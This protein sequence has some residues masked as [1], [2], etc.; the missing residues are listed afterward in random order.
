[1]NN[2]RV[3]VTDFGI[4]RAVTS[5]TITQTGSV[6][7]SVHYFSPEH[8]KGINT[9]EKSDLYSL[10]IV[11]YQML[12]GK[13]PF[14]GESP[15]S[16]AL[17]HLQ[18]PFDEP[19]VV[20]P[21]I[22]QSVENVILKSMRKNPSERYDSA[23]D[24]L[25]D[26]DT[27]LRPERLDEPRA[28]FVANHDM[29]ETR[30][31]PAIRGNVAAAS[32]DTAVRKEQKAAV[33]DTTSVNWQEEENKPKGW[34]KPLLVVGI[35]LLLLAL[36][37]LGFR[38]VLG[39]LD[40]G[41]VE[42]PNV[43]G[44]TEEAAKTELEKV[45]LK[46]YEP[47]TREFQK[48]I[49]KGEVYEQSPTNVTVKKGRYIEISVSDGPEMKE[50]KSYVGKKLQEA[51]DE[52]IAL[53]IA[54]DR[55]KVT[56]EHSEEDA[57][58]ILEQTPNEGEMLNPEIAEVSFVVSKGKET[59]PMEDLTDWRLK[60]AR[61]WLK[62]KELVFEEDSIIYEASYLHDKDHVIGVENYAVGDQ[63]PKGTP[64]I[65]KV[66]SGPPADSKTY[67]FNVRISPAQAGKSSE[68]K[69]IYS[70]ATGENIEGVKQTIDSTVD[71]PVTVILAPDTVA[72]VMVLR[73]NEVL[74]TA[75]IRYDEIGAGN[76]S[77]NLTIPGMGETEPPPD[78][79]EDNQQVQGEVDN[80][81]GENGTEG[82]EEGD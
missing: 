39:Q 74:D 77:P 18:E 61:S 59:V 19:R 36:L 58:T 1:G 13:L 3:K 62:S 34:K 63:V 11:L 20:N 53:G 14:L 23:H 28:Q 8:A 30:I 16:V 54:E 81:D 31:M 6:I 46:V 26:L 33:S 42:V 57:G 12:T 27:C 79:N 75:E 82:K 40:P 45:G 70:D 66:S 67:T 64:I 80:S 56:E 32:S 47:I 44:M 21:H 4:A 15:I 73:D 41:E 71:I 50:L 29:D 76:D 35:T 37:L 65:L 68:V 51:K 78:H 9:G 2:G 60:D 43:I 49:P 24:M 55:I 72:R 10:G 52:L 69:I 48:D 25:L 5:S 7:G 38:W 17:K 22:P